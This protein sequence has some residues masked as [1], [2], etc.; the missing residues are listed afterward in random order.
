MKITDKIQAHFNKYIFFPMGKVHSLIIALWILHT[1]TFSD[2]YGFS[3][4]TTGYLYVTGPKGSGKTLVIDLCE[5]LALNSERGVDMS[6]ST[7][8][9]LIDSVK[10]ALLI[11][12]VD[13]WI[14]DEVR[15]G[16]LN[17]GYK[18]GGFVWRTGTGQDENGKRVLEKFFTFGPKLLAGIGDRPVPDTI[19]NRSIPI[20]MRRINKNDPS[21]R[22]E[23]YFSFKAGPVAEKLVE[24]IA[25]WVKTNSEK[26]NSYEPDEGDFVNREFE[27]AY[28]F[29]QL[30]HAVGGKT[31]EKEARESLLTLLRLRPDV[32]D[33]HVRV[34]R[35]IKA[36]FEEADTDKLSSPAVIAAAGYPETGGGRLLSSLLTPFG[37][38]RTTFRI[39]NQTTKGYR[40]ESFEDVWN[41]YL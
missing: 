36:A 11:D 15:R 5:P 18:H 26:I 16:V 37:V 14:K 25:E 3:P 13:T 39:N 23:R 7:M 24:E 40:K 19:Y 28:P 27:V 35:A 41:R 29:L 31:M 9:R 12:E 20:E 8:F 30:A 33:E 6:A 17:G 10:P 34:L 1:W 38:K 21:E 22:R 4:W 32:D 2:E